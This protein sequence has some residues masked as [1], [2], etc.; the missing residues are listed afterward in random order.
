MHGL[1]ENAFIN[2]K[3]RSHTITA[4]IEVPK[5]AKGVIIAQAGRF[6]GWSLYMKGG[7]VHHVYNFG[8]LQ[9]FTVSSAKPLAPGKPETR[10]R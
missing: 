10:V 3:G 8:G 2:I 1:A 6:A 4:E 9:R 7:R 5:A